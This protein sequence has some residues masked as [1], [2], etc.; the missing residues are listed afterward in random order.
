MAVLPWRE[1]AVLAQGARW[2]LP[3]RNVTTV[4]LESGTVTLENDTVI[5]KSGTVILKNDTVILKSYTVMLER[6]YCHVG[7][8]Q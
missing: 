5:L 8:R 3:R 2:L 4:T 1:L 6:D 7:M